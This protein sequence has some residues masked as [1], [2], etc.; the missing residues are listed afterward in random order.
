MIDIVGILS[1]YWVWIITWTFFLALIIIL[2]IIGKIIY[3]KMSLA[4]FL[5]QNSGKIERN[6][7]KDYIERKIIDIYA[8]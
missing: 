4:N 1:A 7:K 2:I 5:E 8:R 3:S 6:I